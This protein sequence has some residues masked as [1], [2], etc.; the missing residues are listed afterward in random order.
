MN[1]SQA[2][3]IIVT[4]NSE[5][6]ITGC[7]TALTEA[8]LTVR[9]VDNASADGT[10]ALIEDRFPG[11]RLTVNRANVGFAAAV[12]QAL[13]ETDTDTLLLV[14]PDCTMPAATARALIMML[15]VHP[16]VG[17]V[18]PRLVDPRGAI[19]ISAHP[20]ETWTTVLAS[21]FGGGLL[22][23]WLRRLLCGPRR[24]HVYDACHDP[25][26]PVAVDWLSGAC[27]AVRTSLLKQIGGLDEGYFMYYEDEE[28]CLQAWRRG[29]HVLYVP[30]VEAV[31]IG[32]ASCSDPS[33]IWPHL[34]QSQLRFFA[35]HHPETYRIVRMLVLI[36]A[37]LGIALARTRQPTRQAKDNP[38]IRA[39]THVARIARTAGP[40]STEGRPCTS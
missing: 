5:A 22:P 23:V 32:G 26:P 40:V 6:Q 13:A 4:H 38:R 18:G 36:R 17:V 11:V 30:A 21:R 35:R 8:G 7:L 16:H 29:A 31:H 14:N 1:Q 25:G 20:F 34:Y 2:T 28:L 12:N 9:V 10:T 15:R 33:R 24:R 27:L 3:A 19:A 39:W 37:V